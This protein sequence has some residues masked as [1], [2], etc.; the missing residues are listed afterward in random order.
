M[1]T[2][3]GKYKNGKINWNGEEYNYNSNIFY[4]KEILKTKKDMVRGFYIMITHF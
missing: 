2:F 1:L 3:K 4:L